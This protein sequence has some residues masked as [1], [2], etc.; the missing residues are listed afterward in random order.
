[1]KKA[2]S[3]NVHTKLLIVIAVIAVLFALFHAQLYYQI[4]LNKKE[5]HKNN[6]ETF[7]KEV[8]SIMDQNTKENFEY[9]TAISQ[10]DGIIDFVKKPNKDWFVKKVENLYEDNTFERIEFFDRNHKSISVTNYP[11]TLPENLISDE[12]IN[13]LSRT[14]FIHFYTNSPKGIVE[15]FGTTIQSENSKN[16][17]A[18]GTVFITRLLD[19]KY[20]SFLKKTTQSDTIRIQTNNQKNE[21]NTLITATLNLKNWKGVSQSQL[22]FARKNLLEL[23][24]IK[25]TVDL[26]AVA[27]TLSILICLY[28]SKKWFYTPLLTITRI[29]ETGNKKYIKDLKK[30]TGEFKYIGAIF[31]DKS[32]R[33]TELVTAKLKAEESDRLKTSFLSN[34]SHE[35]RTPMNA[36]VGFTDLLL[37][38]EVDKVEQIEYL[39]V[40]EKSGKNLISII[41]DLIEMSKIDSQQIKPNFNA[42][43]LE[44]CINELYDTIKITIK[45]SKKIDFYILKNN[46]PAK[47]NIKTDEVKLKQ[48]I[49]NLVNNAIKFTD[50]GYV[51]FGYEIDEQNTTIK[52]TVKDTGFGI[53][54]KSQPYIFDRFRRV[55]GEKSI[56]AGGLGLGL[57]ISKAYVE[58]L[59]GQIELKSE[60]GKGSIFTF[61]IPLQYID[62][63]NITVKQVIKPIGLKKGEEEGTILIA[64]DDNINF[65]LFQKIMKTKNYK[66]IR[67]VN[68]QEAVDICLNNPNIDL[69][70]MDIKMP[71]MDGFEA[72]E[73]IQPFRPDLP[74]V[75]QTA[76]SS[77]ADKKKIFKMGFNDYI[78]KP[79]NRENLFEIIDRVF[80]KP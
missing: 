63:K 18:L 2:K 80:N 11:S 68:G 23:K 54:K 75:A 52:F 70:L 50:D 35:I 46:E 25:Q 3:L 72:L 22:I 36:I 40:I 31:E 65:L 55:G 39:S 20:I 14:K 10:T 62:S 38:T 16:S 26:S 51:A 32:K 5:I 19:K 56:K 12:A 57:S 61:T 69:V 79:I 76:F 8:N 49:V 37:N 33:E 53:E 30:S 43:N 74:I 1:M 13:N 60:I 77:N 78:T 7:I 9:L 6:T 59:G 64:E 48:I 47:F 66:I 41:D 34:L 42:V 73:K 17:Q 4:Y 29:L 27:L 28:F 15:I 71:I 45:K 44:S 21:N 58:M 67:A 24:S